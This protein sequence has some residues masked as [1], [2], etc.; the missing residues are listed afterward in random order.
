MNYF[1]FYLFILFC[2]ISTLVTNFL[3]FTYDQ[4]CPVFFLLFPTICD[5]PV[6]S[7]YAA[8]WQHLNT[9]YRKKRRVIIAVI[10]RFFIDDNLK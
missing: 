9:V 5:T 10:D 7:E 1:L 6:I 4:F 8:N 3:F 2:A